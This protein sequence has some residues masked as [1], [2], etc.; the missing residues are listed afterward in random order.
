MPE[1]GF[2]MHYPRLAGFG[3][4]VSGFGSAVSLSVDLHTI[5]D[6]LQMIYFVK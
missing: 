4:L 1:R 2:R 5:G 6:D 3:L